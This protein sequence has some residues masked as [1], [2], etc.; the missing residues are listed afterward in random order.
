ME[1]FG[2][3]SKEKRKEVSRITFSV[4]P[5]DP[6]QAEEFI[7]Q[8]FVSPFCNEFFLLLYMHRKQNKSISL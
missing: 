6:R 4:M 3:F 8:L 2:H 5:A 7:T 1:Y